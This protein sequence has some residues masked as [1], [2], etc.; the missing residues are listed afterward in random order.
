M[1]SASLDRWIVDTPIQLS[2]R[3]AMYWCTLTSAND[4]ISVLLCL[5]FL[6]FIGIYI[7]LIYNNIF[8]VTS[9]DM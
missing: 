8:N 9:T 6:R 5:L 1:V 3:I 7:I 4:V 2:N